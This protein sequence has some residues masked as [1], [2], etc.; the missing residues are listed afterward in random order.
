MSMT[1]LGL[2]SVSYTHLDVYKRQVSP[3]AN[4]LVV[5]RRKKV[6]KVISKCPFNKSDH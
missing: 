4:P 1:I 2:I 6:S 3:Y 5:V